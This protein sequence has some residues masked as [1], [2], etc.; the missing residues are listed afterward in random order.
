MDRNP[1]NINPSDLLEFISN[2]IICPICFLPVYENSEC[3]SCG[4]IFCESCIEKLEY[5]DRCPHCREDTFYDTNMLMTR[6]LGQVKVQCN[7]CGDLICRENINMHLNVCIGP[8]QTCNTCG[9]REH[10]KL[11]QCQYTFCKHCDRQYRKGLEHTHL[12]SCIGTFIACDYCGT[13]MRRG[14]Y[15]NHLT[16][17]TAYIYNCPFC[18]QLIHNPDDAEHLRNC[19]EALQVC[20]G[21]GQIYR[22]K[23]L[24]LCNSSP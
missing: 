2:A 8:L 18:K 14:E 21:C 24:H 23:N 17:C 12:D 22:I 16:I 15:N 19:P 3:A 1:E 9:V 11:H 10:S 7:Y 5:D 6:I 4:T 13:S 20:D